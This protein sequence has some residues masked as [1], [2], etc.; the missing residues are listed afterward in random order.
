MTNW[1]LLF[2]RTHLYLGLLLIPWM[3]VYALSTA[4][5]NHAEFFRPYR[6]GPEWVLLWEKDYAP[7]VPPPAANDTAALQA[8]TRQLLADQGIGTS[9]AVRRQGQRLNINVPTFW[10]PRRLTY[11]FTTKKLRAE[12][13]K[14]TSLDVLARLHE[15]TSYGRGAL[16]NL[17]AA[18]VDLFCLAT[19]AWIATGL[20]LWWKLAVTRRWGFLAL[21]G[22]FA[23]MVALL[24]TV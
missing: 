21:G 17:W 5:F 12:E 18:F 23:T 6:A 14:S 13:R 24:L 4:V 22:G 8:T 9:F 15:R 11:D 1:N 10:H 2:R 20:Y 7:A 19:L 3:L 16:N